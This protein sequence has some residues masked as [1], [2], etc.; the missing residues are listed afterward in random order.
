[1]KKFRLREEGVG[2]LRVERL[3]VGEG[4]G[5]AEGGK[6]GGMEGEREGER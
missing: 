3:R 5:V 1:M 6:K 4:E 2:R